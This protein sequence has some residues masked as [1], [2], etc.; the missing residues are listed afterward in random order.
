MD[1]LETVHFPSGPEGTI[2]LLAMFFTVGLLA[3]AISLRF[4]LEGRS[5][6][7]WTLVPATVEECSLDL[8]GYGESR[9]WIVHV[10]Y[11]YV[12]G[13]RYFSGQQIALRY[14]GGSLEEREQALYEKLQSA[15]IIGIRF[16]PENP[17]NSMIVNGQTR[18]AASAMLGGIVCVMVGVIAVLVIFHAPGNAR[19]IAENVV[20]IEQEIDR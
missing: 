14:S 9:K 3:I 1:F 7:D 10:R 8:C 12:V 13:E 20:I 16:D 4:S 17:A 6:L 2:A 5:T 11:E 18:G 19:E 15:K